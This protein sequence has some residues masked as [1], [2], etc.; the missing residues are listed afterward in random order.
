MNRIV[1]VTKLTR[2]EELIL[3]HFSEETVAF[4]LETSEQS[5]DVYKEED[6]AYKEALNLIR[7]QIPADLACTSIER[8]DLP[9][10][11]FRDDR[12]ICNHSNSAHGQSG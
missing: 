8:K 5:I 11:V 7:Q 1:I 12:T 9:T 10:F 4:I 6:R 3:K 2:L